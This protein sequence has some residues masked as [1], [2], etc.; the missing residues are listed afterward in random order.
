VFLTETRVVADVTLRNAAE[1]RL[2]QSETTSSRLAAQLDRE[3]RDTKGEAL[4]AGID[5]HLNSLYAVP[6]VQT[7]MGE[8][9]ADNQEEEYI[10]QRKLT[11]GECL[12][13]NP[14]SRCPEA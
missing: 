14:C 3:G 6:E 9:S 10:P 2:V 5:T 8:P 12:D 13:S 7:V 1:N 4:L 11:S